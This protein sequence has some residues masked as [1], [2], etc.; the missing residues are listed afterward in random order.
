[1]FIVP[2]KLEKELRIASVRATINEDI[3]RILP[4]HEDRTSQSSEH[5]IIPY[6]YSA[7]SGF[8]GQPGDLAN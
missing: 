4:E 7:L 1:M 5:V 2:L 3:E 6:S 8:K